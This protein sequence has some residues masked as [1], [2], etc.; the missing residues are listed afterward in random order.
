MNQNDLDELNA[1]IAKLLRRYG[2]TEYYAC[3]V[4]FTTGSG[5]AVSSDESD[6][7]QGLLLLEFMQAGLISFA[8]RLTRLSPYAAAGALKGFVDEG[9]AALEER[10]R[11]IANM[12]GGPSASA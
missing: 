11:Q 5:M 12:T 2:I 8:M 6:P 4:N 1:D 10:Q 7:V 9:R 3:G